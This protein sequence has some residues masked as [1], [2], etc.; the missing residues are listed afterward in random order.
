MLMLTKVTWLET[1]GNQVLNER[2]LQWSGPAGT[3]FHAYDA[4][5]ALRQRVF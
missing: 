2:G 3:F 4:P 5:L 1:M